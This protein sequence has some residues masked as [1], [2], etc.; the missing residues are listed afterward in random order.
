M[1]IFKSW[2]KLFIV[3]MLILCVSG[4]CFGASSD[5]IYV[6]KDV[7][8]VYMQNINAKFDRIIEELHS[9]RQELQSQR[10]E[11]QS[12]S[13]AINEL[14]KSVAVMSE[15]I[16]RNFE[17]LSGRIDGLDTRVNDLRNDIY[18]WLVILGIIIAL[19]SAQRFLQWR[20]ER[21]AARKSSITLEE[22]E[23]LIEAK[24]SEKLP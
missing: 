4:V 14:N 21:Q 7:F 8:E 2:R 17:T 24:L 15:R 6:R 12:Q 9:Q 16:D 22:V 19:P 11:L 5:D 10:Q 20:E 3:F 13:Q 23:R 18:L 1:R